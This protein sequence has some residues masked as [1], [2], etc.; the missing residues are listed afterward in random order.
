MPIPADVDR[1]AAPVSIS[2]IYPHLA[3]FGSVDETG[4]GAV[5]PWAGRL[6]L[7]TY[8]SHQPQGSNDRLVSLDETLTPVV[9]PESIGGTPANR[10][11]HRES[12]QLILG[13][14]FISAAG[15]VRAVGYNH[16]PGRHTATLRHLTDPANKV[17]FLGMEGELYEVDVHTLAVE[18][19]WEAHTVPGSHAKGGWTSQGRIVVAN[20]GEWGWYDRWQR[21]HRYRGE[22]GALVEWD[23]TRW[24]LIERKQFCEVTGPGDV[25][26][27]AADDAPIWATG[28]DERSVL[29]K[30]LD[31]GEWHTFRLPKA[32]YTYDGGHGWHTEWPRIRE[33]VPGRVLM[34]M[35]GMF[36]RFPA[37]FRRGSTGGLRPL[38]TY[39]KMVVDFCAWQG[40]L[41]LA[42]NDTSLFD[43]PLA[44]RPQSNLWFCPMT[45]LTRLGRP[46]GFGGPWVHTHVAAG[47]ASDP[48]LLA[49]FG[50]RVLHLR[51]ESDEPVTFT[52][53]LD[54]SGNGTWQPYRSISVPGCGYAFHVFPRGTSAEWLRVRANRECEATAYCHY[55]SPGAKRRPAGFEALAEV[56]SDAPWVG[57]LVR[58]MGGDRTSLQFLAQRVQGEHAGE[59]RYYEIDGDLR[60]RQVEDAN[61]SAWLRQHAAVTE[62]DFVIDAASVLLTDAEGR[63]YRLPKGDPAYAQPWPTGWPRGLREV[64]TERALLNCQGTFYEVPR[65][66]SGGLAAMRPVCTHR[67]R[68][69]DFCSWR[70]LLVLAGTR[71]EAPADAHHFRAVDGEAALWFGTVDD[72][73]RL[74]K[75]RGQ[76]GPWYQTPVRADDPSD[77]YLMTG[78][79]HKLLEL[80]HDA[81]QPVEFTVEVDFLA[82]GEWSVYRRFTVPAGGSVRH[83]F[84]NGYNAHWL[85]VRASVACT[86]TCLLTYS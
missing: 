33:V 30:L 18:R 34:T 17:Y 16:M 64:V 25:Q 58:P 24:R 40:R 84:P 31:Q 46:S 42:C 39:L 23:G 74:G 44:G 14:Y 85:R 32:S 53:E 8:S 62:P 22:T 63:R 38:S 56:D 26:G 78:F 7:V 68:I 76:G 75:P 19:L 57:G 72:L 49:G 2:G 81:G 37:G 45:E 59:P 27:A 61:A 36:Y 20:N 83:R 28:W 13:P 73:W 48:Y 55:A 60:L 66:S 15:H 51:H 86:A 11:I 10:L 65:L 1:S 4:I 54:S 35:H 9:H 70:G 52:L 6:W 3:L 77:P 29:L 50:K 41:V 5:V 69:T 21:D 80:S 67:R 71:T 43:N 79:D 47:E 82:T 12:N